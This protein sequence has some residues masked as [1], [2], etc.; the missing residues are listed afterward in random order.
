MTSHKNIQKV[1]FLKMNPATQLLTDMYKAVYFLLLY[2]PPPPNCGT[3]WLTSF[4]MHEVHTSQ[5][6]V[7]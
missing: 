7:F 3:F 1:S 5:K 6:D 2:R 4:N